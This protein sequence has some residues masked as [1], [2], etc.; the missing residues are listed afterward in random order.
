MRQFLERII[1]LIYPKVCINCGKYGLYLCESCYKDIDLCK[2]DM[3]FYCLRLSKKARICES[4]KSKNKSSLNSIWWCGHY[5]GVL[6]EIIHNLKYDG[7][8]E[9]SDILSSIMVSR[10][11]KINDI[12]SFVLVPVPIHRKKIVQRG[13]NQSELLA[14]NISKTLDIKGGLALSRIK[15]T[16]TQVGLKRKQRID[17]VFGSIVCTDKELI[18][19]QKVLLIDDVATTGATLNECAKVLKQNGAKAVYALVVAR[20]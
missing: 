20:D 1:D 7:V 10:V 15:N 18:D 14:R 11:V 6:K 4:C 19:G 12:N 13:F 5:K 9:L 16:K 8:I 2:T 3:C 17:N